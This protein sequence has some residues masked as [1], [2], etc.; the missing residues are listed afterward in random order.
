MTTTSDQLANTGK[1]I[2]LTN[3]NVLTLRYNF[4]ALAEIEKEHGSI[5]KLVEIM[6]QGDKGPLFATLGHALW[7]G[8]SRKM[9]LREFMDLL[10]PSQ[11]NQ[12]SEAFGNAMKE[13]MGNNSGEAEAAEAA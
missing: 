5:Q 6:S 3:G 8:T 7:A 11:T 9:P 13:A 4:S 2:E 12:Y 1:T 10:S